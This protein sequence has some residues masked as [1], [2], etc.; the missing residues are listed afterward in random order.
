MADPINALHPG[1]DAPA[2]RQP[3]GWQEDALARLAGLVD[4]LAC[5][6][7]MLG[8]LLIARFGAIAAAA[9]LAMGIPVVLRQPA[10]AFRA[11]LNAWPLLAFPAAAIL[12]TF[13]SID[14]AASLR[15]GVQLAATVAIGVW[16]AAFLTPRAAVSAL[17]AALTA[18]AFASL[19]QLGGRYDWEGEQALVGLFEGKN[20]FAYCISTLIL[21]ASVVLVDRGQSALFRLMAAAALVLSPHLLIEARSTG[22]IVISLA[23]VALMAALQLIA[24]LPPAVRVGLFLGLLGVCLPLAVIG[25]LYAHHV[26]DL[27]ELLGKDASLTG[28]T[29]LW[30]RGM[31]FFA[32]HPIL[33]VGYRAFWLAGHSEAEELWY[34]SQ[35]P[36]GTGFNF[37]NLYLNTAVD[38]GLVGLATLLGAL[39]ATA[40]R[41]LACLL[42]APQ[43]HQIL[44]VG[45]FLFV[46]LSSPIEV[47]LTYQFELGT[48]LLCF[49]WVHTGSPRPRR[50]AAQAGVRGAA[51]KART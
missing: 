49:I 25:L 29:Y 28:R 2:A 44:A 18:V 47:T 35:V 31:E 37:H 13:W 42:R 23:V 46:I 26:D 6:A 17:L 38:L 39:F 32:E 30:R 14:P 5:F 12:S 19:P 41:C 40:R 48:V 11:I 45:A 7:S 16:A 43:P 50:P 33:G 1:G 20:Y 3:A 34:Y 8:L 21:A 9:F 51:A 24:W 27:L 4:W 36:S 15:A 10:A 22:A